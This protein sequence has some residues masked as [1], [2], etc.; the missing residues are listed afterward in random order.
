MS[1][2]IVR[3]GNAH[4]IRIPKRVMEECGLHSNEQVELYVMDGKIIIEKTF[5]HQTLEER[6]A[7]YGG[8]LGPYTEFDWGSPVGRE[9]W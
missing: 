3:W 4:G 5:R 2:Q 7:A 6:A 8:R 9:V 1:T